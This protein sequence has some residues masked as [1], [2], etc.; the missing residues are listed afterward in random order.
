MKAINN[1]N[2]KPCRQLKPTSL[3]RYICSLAVCSV[4]ALLSPTPLSLTPIIAQACQMNSSSKSA[5]AGGGG[6]HGGRETNNLWKRKQ[7]MEEK[8]TTGR[9]NN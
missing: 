7:L 8:T 9:E 3:S 2:N 5:A 4:G 6:R 1:G